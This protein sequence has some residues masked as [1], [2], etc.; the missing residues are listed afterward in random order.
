MVFVPRRSTRSATGSSRSSASC[1]S[2]STLSACAS[3]VFISRFSPLDRAVF[4][5]VTSPTARRLRREQDQIQQL[6]DPPYVVHREPASDVV[7][8]VLFEAPLVLPRQDHVGQSAPRR[9][10][11]LQQYV[12]PKAAPPADPAQPRAGS[13]EQRARQWSRRYPT[14]PR[15]PRWPEVQREDH[16][17]PHGR[18]SGAMRSARKWCLL[19]PSASA[20]GDHS[21]RGRPRDPAERARCQASRADPSYGPLA[22]RTAF[23]AA[24]RGCRRPGKSS[25]GTRSEPGTTSRARPGECSTAGSR[26][27]WRAAGRRASLSSPR[28]P[29]RG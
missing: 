20:R 29:P 10:Q 25:R 5:A 21:G 9:R 7:A 8:D 15:S 1:R 2:Y 14:D 27:R 13:S 11:H 3:I 19:L 17:P 22:R 26:K 16:D 4:V 24:E 12:K 28:T 18:K 23:R 6:V